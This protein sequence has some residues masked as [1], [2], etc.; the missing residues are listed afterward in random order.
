MNS[1][2]RHGRVR[3][4]EFMSLYFMDMKDPRLPLS[5]ASLGLS[6]IRKGKAALQLPSKG[7]GKLEGLFQAVKEIT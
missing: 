3:E 6:L 1:V 2:R 5:Y 7:E 4:M